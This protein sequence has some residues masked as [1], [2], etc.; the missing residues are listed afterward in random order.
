MVR[1]LSFVFLIFFPLLFSLSCRVPRTEIQPATVETNGNG[2]GE[3]SGCTGAE[4]SVL[5]PGRT[6]RGELAGGDMDSFAVPLEDNQFLF[7]RVMQLGVDLVVSARHPDGSLMTEIDNLPD[8]PEFV[9]LTSDTPGFYTIELRPF[10]PLAGRGVYFIQVLK[11]QPAAGTLHGEVDQLFAEFDESWMP[12]AIVVILRDGEIVHSNAFGMANLEEELPL[13]VTTPIN[14][15][16]I[17]KQFT[18]FAAALLSDRGRL[19]LDDDIRDHLPWLPDFGHRITVRHL[20][21]HTS[22][23]R[24]LDD[25]WTLRGGTRSSLRRS[26]FRWYVERQKELNFPPGEEYLYCNTGYIL[27]GEIVEA[28]TGIPFIEWMHAEVLKPLGM[29]DTFFFHDVEKIRGRFAWSYFVGPDGDF[30]RYEMQPAWYVGAGNVFTTV[31]DIKRWLLHLDEPRICSSRITEQMNRSGKLANGEPISYAFAQDSRNYRGLPVLEHGGGGWGYRS[32]IMRF[33]EQRFTV[34]VVSNF[35]FG[36]SFSLS[37]RI[38]DLYLEEYFTGGKPDDEYVNRRRALAVDPGKLDRC[39]GT[40]RQSSG[41]IAVI[42]RGGN[43]LTAFVAGLDPLVLYP[44][45]DKSFFIKEADLQIIFDPAGPEEAAGLTIQ[46]PTDTVFYSRID[47]AGIAEPVF[48]AYEGRFTSEELDVQYSV[49]PGTNG[50][51]VRTPGSSTIPCTH[52]HDDLFRCPRFIIEFD[53]NDQSRVDGFRISCE[54]SRNI[55]FVRSQS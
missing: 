7:A 46:S 14:I 42:A 48:T 11:Q 52:V 40:Y 54:R 47:P 45:S 31:E 55:R 5:E 50:I 41:A 19:G 17:G 12:G 34:L 51:V 3:F 25:L 8:G 26:D 23:L 30:Q 16:S 29:H 43:S 38:S 49:S 4:A 15:C 21:H 33:P 2:S 20:I 27:L 32:Y 18:A 22:G 35:V 44:G 39:T 28:V 1:H 37:R 36:R 6:G 24:E 13:T 53:R 10:Y 9:S